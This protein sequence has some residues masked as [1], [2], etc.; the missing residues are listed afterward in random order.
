MALTIGQG[1]AVSYNA[2]LNE[3]RR[4]TNQWSENGFLRE[5]E[6]Q[7]GIVRKGL[8]PQIEAT[9]DYR[10]NPNAGFLASD[11]APVSLNKTEVITAAVYDVAEIGAPIVWSN[12]D[13]VQN[14]EENQK[15]DLVAS[16]LKNGIN[17]H[18][19]L[20]EEAFFQTST[21]GFLGFLTHIPD[22]GLGTDGAIDSSVEAWWRSHQGTYVNDTDIEAGMT[23][24]WNA[25]A[26]ASGSTLMPT[27]LVSDGATQALFEGTQQA[28]QRYVDTEELKAGF[29]ILAFKTS[30]Y[31]YSQ[32]GNTRI[33][34]MNPK[35]LMMVVSKAYFRD[36]GETQQIPNA[37]G[38]VKKIY[39]ALQFLTNNRSRL[40]VLHT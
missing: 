33:Y 26:K 5:L 9:L 29:K 27:L 18:D 10:R 31:V 7:G 21:N 16:L 1:L 20:L 32:F 3:M 13:E 39:S 2:V 17:T 36:L 8:G 24:Q 15:V 12:K 11:L 19:D 4:P 37:F 22:N 25:A 38:Y 23:T 34:F 40:A 30:R 28:Q 35:S 6:R 14:P